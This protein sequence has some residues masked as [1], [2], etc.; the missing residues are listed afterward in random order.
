M[1]VEQS[2]ALIIIFRKSYQSF[3]DTIVSHHSIYRSMTSLIHSTVTNGEF[4]LRSQDLEDTIQ[5]VEKNP[6]KF[7][8]DIN[9]LNSRK[10][11]IQQ[12]REEVNRMK[13]RADSFAKNSLENPKYSDVRL[14]SPKPRG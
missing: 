7:R 1:L 12:T 14:F 6:S 4:F 9:E 13:A 10:L 8:I 5:I 2:E 11:F 3:F